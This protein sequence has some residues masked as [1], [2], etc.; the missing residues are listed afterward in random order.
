MSRIG[1]QPVVLPSGV[2]ATLDG[3]TVTIEGK[4]GKLTQTFRPEVTITLEGEELIVT[5]QDDERQTRAFHG[6]TRSLIANMVEGVTNGYEKK[7]E[8]YG[9]GYG[10]EQKGSTVAISCGKSHLEVVAIP[11]GVTV[12]IHTGQARGDT[13]PA[14]FAVKGCD[15]QAVGEFAAQCRSKRKPEPYK[16]K[17][18]RYAGEHVRRKVGKAMAGK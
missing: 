10:I 5:A 2:K 13:D 4:L 1:K 18:L 16:G 7:L 6:L 11:E 15:K 8:I 17:G 14:K 12:D 9:V 3:Q